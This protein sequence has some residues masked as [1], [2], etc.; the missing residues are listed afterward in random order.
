MT[1]QTLQSELLAGP[2]DGA[3]PRYSTEVAYLLEGRWRD[4]RLLEVA[5]TTMQ[6]A[7]AQQLVPGTEIEFRAQLAHHDFFVAL[8]GKALVT[9]SQQLRNGSFRTALRFVYVRPSAGR[10]KAEDPCGPEA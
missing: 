9:D 8:T 7:T 3:E 1:P 2:A 4:A 6:I 5:D 10:A